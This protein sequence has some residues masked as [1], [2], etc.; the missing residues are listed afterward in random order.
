MTGPDRED[1]DSGMAEGRKS[2]ELNPEL[3]KKLQ[4]ALRAGPEELFRVL[5]DPAVEV[6][7]A[8]LRN[9]H[10]AEEHLLALLK[11]RDLPED[12]LKAIYQLKLTESNKRLKLALAQNPGT[13]GPVVQ[14]IL[15]QLFLFELI[16][17]C[18]LPG[19]TPDQKVAAE[20]VILQR[21]STTPLGSKITL[22]RRGTATVVGE[23]LK[24]GNAALMEACLSNPRLREVSVFQFL[25][26]PHAT[27]ESI[28]CV[29]RHPKWKTRPNLQLAI[30][31]NRKTPSVWFTVFLPRLRTPELNNLLSARRLN[32]VQKKLVQEE[33]G[34]RSGRRG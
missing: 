2:G 13:P 9:R 22:A 31:K 16:G 29:A 15:P 3:V 4:S 8:A 24:E 19:A 1:I 27:A 28:S 20:R 26:G 18:Y 23:L 34:R 14:A 33:H 10:L 6:V 7:R 5:T 17:L 32:P 25:N 11:R 21:L 12:L 30:L